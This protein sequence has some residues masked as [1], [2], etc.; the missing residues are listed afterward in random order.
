MIKSLNDF[1]NDDVSN[2]PFPCFFTFFLKFRERAVR[3]IKWVDR[4]GFLKSQ[5]SLWN[6]LDFSLPFKLFSGEKLLK[7]VVRHRI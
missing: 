2:Y 5:L 1:K 7:E 3:K 6:F 4:P